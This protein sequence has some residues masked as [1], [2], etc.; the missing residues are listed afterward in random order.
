[1]PID[2]SGVGYRPQMLSGLQ[3]GRVGRQKEQV[4]VLGHMQPH[5]GMPSSTVEDQ[6]N[7]L[8]RVRADGTGK[9]S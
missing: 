4:N 9:G 2:E 6:N 3:L 8:G 5:A 7:L 1:M